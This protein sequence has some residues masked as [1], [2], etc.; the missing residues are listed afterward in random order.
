MLKFLES[1]D[2]IFEFDWRNLLDCA[3][4]NLNLLFALPLV[5]LQLLPPLLAHRLLIHLHPTPTVTAQLDDVEPFM[6]D[7]ALEASERFPLECSTILFLI[8]K[9]TINF[10]VHHSQLISKALC[11]V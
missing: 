1:G 6:S 3:G 10:I 2:S 11:R 7:V 9:I 5:L 4:N 8:F